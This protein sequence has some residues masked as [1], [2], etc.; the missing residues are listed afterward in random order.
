MRN[1]VL[2]LFLNKI[3]SVPFWIKQIMYLK[4]ADEMREQACEE[5]LEN[6][7]RE[8]LFLTF[9]PTVTF[10]GKTELTERNCGLDSN[11]YN[12]LQCCSEGYN[13]LE[14]SVNTFFSMEEVAKYYEL[15][16]EQGFIIPTVSDE[17]SV[18]SRYISGKI[19]IGE[20]FEEKGI[21]SANQLSEAIKIF[22]H[23]NGKK[24]GE[25]LVSLNY[26]TD[27][28]LRTVLF[29]KEEAQKRIVLNYSSLP[30]VQTI[31]SD[32]VKY[33][34]NELEQLQE[35]NIKLKHKM[36]LLLKMVKNNV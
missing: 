14:I 25:I 22:Q 21:I 26:I 11:I 6:N 31:F 33:Y 18:M 8:D 16:V 3:L 15:C 4:L 23:S 28:D 36:N 30:K 2:T 13:M 17:I 5:F 34:K 9:R 27:K 24:F 32:E 7:R 20:Y 35:E 1:N 29:F 19:R 10:K 12:F